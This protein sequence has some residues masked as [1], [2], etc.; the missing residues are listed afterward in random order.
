VQCVLERNSIGSLDYIINSSSDESESLDFCQTTFAIA[1][2]FHHLV[3]N[4][5]NAAFPRVD[6][7][8]RTRGAHMRRIALQHP[9]VKYLRPPVAFTPVMDQCGNVTNFGSVFRWTARMPPGS[10][11]TT[12]THTHTHSH[13]HTHAQHTYRRE[14][15][16]TQRHRN[17]HPTR[18]QLKGDYIVIHPRSCSQSC[19]RW[20]TVLRVAA[21][22]TPA[23][24]GK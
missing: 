18:S 16:Q 12:H 5:I 10:E 23:Q 7:W 8:G 4:R 6:G 24:K 15:P 19:S 3:S 13:T 9:T 17:K 14:H 11:H 1:W 20:V 2:K 21:S 22:S